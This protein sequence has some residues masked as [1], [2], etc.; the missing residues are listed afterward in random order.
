MQAMAKLGKKLA[1][2]WQ[3]SEIHENFS[4]ISR[5]SSGNFSLVNSQAIALSIAHF[6]NFSINFKR[7]CRT[8]LRSPIPLCQA[9]FAAVKRS[10]LGIAK[11]LGIIPNPGF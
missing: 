10:G 5:F 1:K 2:N 6:Y 8:C 11:M 7:A 3:K 4:R 9:K